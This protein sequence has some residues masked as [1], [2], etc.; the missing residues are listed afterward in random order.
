ML[1]IIL[2]EKKIFLNLHTKYFKYLK[3]TMADQINPAAISTKCLPMKLWDK[4]VK[5]GCTK[6]S[7]ALHSLR[8]TVKIHYNKAKIW[9]NAGIF[10]I[11]LSFQIEHPCKN[12]SY[13]TDGVTEVISWNGR[14]CADRSLAPYRS[15]LCGIW[16]ELCRFWERLTLGQEFTGMSVTQ[17][18]SFWKKYC[19]SFCVKGRNAH[20]NI[21]PKYRA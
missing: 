2:K 16:L 11:R 15:S 9:H 14:I 12:D 13:N 8:S 6:M 1:R 19:L 7:K 17:S 20:P 5:E 18:E 21:K 10:K 3:F 4:G